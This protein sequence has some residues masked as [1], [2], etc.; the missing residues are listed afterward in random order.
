MDFSKK[1]IFCLLFLACFIIYALS[2]A[3][4]YIYSG[5]TVVPVPLPC[6]FAR[7]F[8]GHGTVNPFE[9]NN[10]GVDIIVHIVRTLVPE[11]SIAKLSYLKK[12]PVSKSCFSMRSMQSS[13]YS[14]ISPFGKVPATGFR[15]LCSGLSPPSV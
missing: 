15:F 13:F 14:G 4:C 7:K 10:R 6:S 12:T 1:R 3:V 2:T 9:K 8:V 11:D 5:K